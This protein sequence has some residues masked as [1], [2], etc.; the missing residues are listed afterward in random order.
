MEVKDEQ[1][2][3]AKKNKS[4]LEEKEKKVSSEPAKKSTDNSSPPKKPKNDTI[5]AKTKPK[6]V[7]PRDYSDWDKFDVDAACEEVDK[8]HSE[9]GSGYT[10]EEEELENERLKVEAMAEKDRGN[11]WFKKGNYDKAIERYTRGMN[12]DP[13]NAVLPANRA[14]ALLKKGQFGA[15]ETHCTLALSID[16]TY[17]K[18]FQR[19]ASAR[20]GLDK[21]DLAIQDY[22][23]VL[24]LEPKNKAAQTERIRLVE[25][26]NEKLNCKNDNDQTKPSFEE[27]MKGALAKKQFSP[28][29]QGGELVAN[30]SK[31]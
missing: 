1:L 28:A 15:A 6:A 25:K 9:E 7:K 20:I 24:K 17:I 29:M 26:L 2:K 10:S 31:L 13:L 23:E 14:M 30:K 27:K 18:A 5:V 21:L 19:R 12:L 4:K 8:S 16:S 22:D 3:Q 11:E